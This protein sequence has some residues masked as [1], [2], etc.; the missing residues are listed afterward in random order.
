MVYQEGLMVEF[1][2][3]FSHPPFSSVAIIIVRAF[4][5]IAFGNA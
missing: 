4:L 2:K 1:L 5:K 3:L